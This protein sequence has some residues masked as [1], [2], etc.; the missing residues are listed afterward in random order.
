MYKQDRPTASQQRP[1]N[2]FKS[3]A[4]ETQTPAVQWVV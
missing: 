4:D 2:K 1:I 3:A